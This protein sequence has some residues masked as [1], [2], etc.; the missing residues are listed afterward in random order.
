M[1]FPLQVFILH[2]FTPYHEHQFQLW[3]ALWGE[4]QQLSPGLCGHLLVC[5]RYMQAPFNST[6]GRL[7][8]GK[9]DVA[10]L[11][12]YAVGMFCVGHLAD[13]MHLRKFLTF[14]MLASAAAVCAFG[15]AEFLEIHR[16]WYFIVIQIVGGVYRAGFCIA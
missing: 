6:G 2:Y 9:L 3:Q 16:L 4:V 14:G 15:M 11:G 7:L 13:R 10:F 8:L 5:C 1:Q 12:A